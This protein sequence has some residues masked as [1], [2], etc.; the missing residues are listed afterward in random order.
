MGEPM[1][2]G[3]AT[4]LAT[5]SKRTRTREKLLRLCYCEESEPH[6]LETVTAFLRLS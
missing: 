6:T 2:G 1:M 4:V 5:L 3:A